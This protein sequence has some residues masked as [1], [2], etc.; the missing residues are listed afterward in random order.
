VLDGQSPIPFAVSVFLS[1]TQVASGKTAPSVIEIATIVGVLVAVIALIVDGRRTRLSLGLN[2]L[3]RLIEQWDHPDMRSRRAGVASALL[4][5]PSGRDHLSDEAL[6]VVNTFELLAFLVR[7]RTLGIK[8]AWVN[9]SPWAIGWWYLYEPAIKGMQA[10]DST[11][12]ED[13]EWLVNRF[14]KYDARRRHLDRERVIPQEKDLTD[15]LW[16]EK[17]LPARVAFP[18]TVEPASLGERIRS[19]LWGGGQA[20]GA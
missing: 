18:A 12:F 19:F 2:N 17:G 13:Y 4:A 3:W 15:F 10:E 16:A 1:A 8:H 7:A 9:F 20:G 6:D 11:L 14:I 5:D